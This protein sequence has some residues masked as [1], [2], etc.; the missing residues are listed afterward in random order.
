MKIGVVGEGMVGKAVVYGMQKLGHDVS[1]CDPYLYENSTIND[2]IDSHVC[3]ICV[4]TPSAEDGSCDTST[5]ESVLSE[6]GENAYS[7]VVAIKSTVSPGTTDALQLCHPL[8][9]ICFV[10]EFLRERMANADFVENHD[11]LA[12][13]THSQDVF[14]TIVAAHGRYPRQTVMMAP[15][16][17]EFLKY[18]NNCYNATLVTLANSF[19]EICKASNANYN[20]VKSAFIMRDHVVD[21]YL[22]VNDSCRGFGGKCLPKDMR[23]MSR[24]A[25]R[26]NVNVEFFKMM[27]HENAKHPTTVFSGMRHEND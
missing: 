8:L 25:G 1:V 22:D 11:L 7:G 12:V 16:N 5:V 3:F 10:P 24:L 17:A 9:T 19:Y 20:A 18:Y 23:A 15:I 14:N 4:P 27:L 26:L 2:V 6:L 21:R 13:G